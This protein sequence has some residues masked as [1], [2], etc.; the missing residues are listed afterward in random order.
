MTEA[1]DA[2]TFRLTM[3]D[4]KNGMRYLIDTGADVS[5][6]PKIAVRGKTTLSKYKLYAANNTL[7]PTYGSKLVHVNLGLRRKLDWTFVVADIKQAIIGADFLA[8]Y[9]LLVDLKHKLL[10]DGITNSKA[11]GVLSESKIGGITTFDHTN[12]YADLLQHFSNITKP[13]NFQVP[14][15][16][17]THHITTT[18]PPVAEPAR[19]L[20]GERLHATR[21]QI[22][23]MLDAGMCRPSSSPWANPLHLV[24]KKGGEWRICGDYRRLNKVTIPDRYP[25][26][27]LHDFVH[28]LEG[29]T[30]FT[31]LDLT[32]AYHQIPVA[33][34]DRPK[35]AVITPL[36]LYEYN[37]MP[38]GLRNAAQTFQR[39]MDC[40]L[41]GLDYC[42]C[43]IDDILIASPDLETHRLHLREVFQRLQDN[44]LS[45][46]P[47]KCVFG[48][49][50]VNYLGYT[51]SSQGTKPLDTR[52]KAINEMEKP[53]DISGLRRFLGVINFYRRFIPNAASTQAPLHEY[54]TNTKKNDKRPIIWNKRAE[55]AFL[56]CKQQLI[57]A[58]LVAHPRKHAVLAIRSDASDA[59]MGAVLEQYHE[60]SWE[61][62]GFFSKKF[63]PTQRNYS[64][65]DRELQAIYSSLKFFKS[66][67]EGRKFIIK[68]DHK[69]LTYAFLQKSAKASP[70]QL[71]QL[72]LIGQFSTEIIYV[73][74]KDNTVADALSRVEAID[75]PVI[76]T[77][78]ELAQ[79]QLT[80]EEIKDLLQDG[81]HS[82]Q[83]RKLRVDNSDTVVYCDVS[84]KEVRPYVPKSLRRKIFNVTHGLA[85]PS[86]RVTRK[87]IGQRFVW[88]AMNKDIT[89]WVKTCLQC[90]KNKV[91]RHNRLVP[92]QFPVP[93]TRF[94]HV[95]LDI[96]GPLPVIQGY[97]YCVTM[98]DRFTR[99][100]EAAP[101]QDISA[102]VV[103][104][105]FVNTWVARF[106]APKTITTD[107]GTQFESQLFK[108]LTNLLGCVRTRTTTYHPA[109]NGIIER[110]HRSL[111]V[112]IRCQ[113]S[114]N[115]L[116]ALP[117]VL[118][119]LR[120]SIKED[121]KATAAELVYGT[122]LRLPAE[123]FFNED[124]TPEPQA[125]LSHFRE[126]MRNVRSTPTAHHNKKR[127]FTH[128]TLYNCTHV[129]VRVDKLR[130]PLEP[131]Y[132]GPYP[133][134][135]RIT[136]RIFK[137]LVKGEATNISVDRLKPAFLETTPEEENESSPV[138]QTA[139][140][141]NPRVYPGKRVRFAT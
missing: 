36:G 39:L 12:H 130:S 62:L 46:N 4:K 13:T 34:E 107:Q 105:A 88:P 96:I 80:D 5:I 72:D 26:P 49:E 22:Q 129:F 92:E 83:L 8:H 121:I 135:E 122:T 61:P 81:T 38:F 109:S 7:I 66:M 74:G 127:A 3:T 126:H 94:D 114:K 113:E 42:H 141:S 128:G 134:S 63:S 84:L 21:S 57:N 47:A 137:I 40:A 99:W 140:P 75:M 24:P 43:Y 78:E 101:I 2:K 111:K 77:T 41:R 100:P 139:Q 19:R 102:Q 138:H 89:E 98:I 10:R 60:G 29:C 123:Y 27:H 85:H 110:W 32:R 119:G 116:Q 86:G 91:H 53:T 65:Y 45:I 52:V 87:M 37:V 136:D 117:I 118:L 48:K 18:G 132:E 70:R 54:L 35:T 56:D 103:A 115:W 133:V 55:K 82:L 131:P 125:F 90:Q 58:T 67:V 14:K 112:A 104:E 68:T 20:A 30:T 120:T 28:N 124:F 64:T 17:V 59:A 76:I 51:I 69:P 11:S 97:R 1:G 71:R 23:H 33:E 50:E 93:D 106:G 6:I 9:G 15:H 95:H 31:T 79:E 44:G 108:A 73:K 16:G 25:I